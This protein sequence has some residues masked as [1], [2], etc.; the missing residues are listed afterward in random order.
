MTIYNIALTINL[1]HDKFS[2][3][4]NALIMNTFILYKMINQ[5]P[6]YKCFILNTDNNNDI[7]REK[8]YKYY[9]DIY[10]ICPFNLTDITAHKFKIIIQVATHFNNDI[11]N[12]I[13]SLNPNVIFGYIILGN[14]YYIDMCNYLYNGKTINNNELIEFNTREHIPNI[15]DDFVWISPHF[16]KFKSYIELKYNVKDILIAPF[17]WEPIFLK[18]KLNRCNFDLNHTNNIN[19][20]GEIN[21]GIFEGNI[22]SVKT[23]II[24]LYICEMANTQ[25]IN[26]TNVFLTNVLKFWNKENFHLNINNLQIKKENILHIDPMSVKLPEYIKQYNINLV[27]SHQIHNEL[28][29]LYLELFY[30]NIPLIHN[31]PYIKEYGFYYPEF[32]IELGFS[33]IKQYKEYYIN[34]SDKLKSYNNN[35]KKCLEQYSIYNKENIDI[36]KKNLD[37]ILLKCEAH[38]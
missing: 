5:L 22:L 28:N 12:S 35:N 32:N 1:L 26:I 9:D 14:P 24:P 3:E 20:T 30:M 6:N 34:S 7:N 10:N 16:E 17:I 2:V 27:I 25:N 36:Y 37:N 13:K 19:I 29:Y 31:S 11:K 18:N 4:T 38:I 8:T 33:K 23:C 15:P 21:I